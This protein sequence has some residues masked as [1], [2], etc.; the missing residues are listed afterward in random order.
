MIGTMNIGQCLTPH[1]RDRSGKFFIMF[2]FILT[3]Y[4]LSI[5]IIYSVTLSKMF[6]IIYNV[7][8]GEI[9]LNL[10]QPPN[11]I[12]SH[13]LM[14]GTRV[15]TWVQATAHPTRSLKKISNSIIF[16][17][18]SLSHNFLQKGLQSST[19]SLK[20]ISNSIIFQTLFFSLILFFKRGSKA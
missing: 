8:L 16:R 18:F 10:Y 20:E 5:F 15:T 19:R 12:N 17:K 3:I 1:A 9:W 7:Y 6:F 11:C 13:C 4:V 2:I 14:P